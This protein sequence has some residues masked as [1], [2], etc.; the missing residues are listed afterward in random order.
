MCSAIFCVP[1]VSHRSEPSSLAE[2]TALYRSVTARLDFVV[3]LDNA[4]SAAQAQVL[5][6]AGTNSLAVVTSRRPLLG[7]SAGGEH[8]VQVDPLGAAD[9]LELLSHT[10]G[11][12]R[13]QTERRSAER[14]AGLCGG[15]PIA[16]CIAAARIASR[17]RRSLARMIDGLSDERARLDGLSAEGTCPCALPSTSPTAPYQLRC[18]TSTGRWVSIR[19]GVQCRGRRRG[20]RGGSACRPPRP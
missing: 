5:L 9:A 10:I 6:P 17:P 20:D 4:V 7:L 15:L 3:L 13:I 18:N 14:L 19:E 12:Q 16:L 1:W 11:S 8:A 2:R